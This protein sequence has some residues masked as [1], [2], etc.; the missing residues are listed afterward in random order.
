MKMKKLIALLLTGLMLLSILAGC[1]AASKGEIAMD[2]ES[3]APMENGA[4]ADG[5]YESLSKDQLGSDYEDTADETPSVTQRKLIRKIYLDTETEDMD[6]LLAAIDSKVNALGGYMESREVYTGSR[7]SSYDSRRHADL[8]IRVP[9]DKLDE[10]VA[11]VDKESNIIS[12]NETSD[13]VTLSYVA[14]QSRMTALQKEEARLLELIDKAANLSELLE[15][16]KRLTEVRTDLENVT[17]QL[18]LYD[19]LVDYGTIE[20]S[21]SEVQ[22]LTPVQEPGFFSRISTGF[23]ESLRNLWT[24]LKELAIFLVVAS[25]Y[26]VTIAAVAFVVVLIIRLSVRRKR[27]ARSKKQPPFTTEAKE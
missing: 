8:V 25:P 4:L 17:S 23:M 9:K 22:K 18:L 26:L 16:E 2:A 1:G 14:V 24:F 6:A 3:F 19:N 11:H 7:Y 12:S 5:I 13:D 15:L 21:I 27:A 10:F 20:V